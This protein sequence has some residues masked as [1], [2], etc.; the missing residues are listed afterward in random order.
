MIVVVSFVVAQLAGKLAVDVARAFTHVDAHALAGS[1]VLPARVIV[2]SMLASELVLLLAA[3][4]TPLVLAVPVRQTL[5]LYAARPRV[6]IAA[7]VGT[8][9]LGPLGDFLMA[10]LSRFLPGLTLGVVPALHE[11]ARS[12]PLWLLWPAFALMPGAGEELIF[13]GVLQ[14][15]AG[16]SAFAIW[17]SGCAFAAFHVDP[18]H[19]VGVLPLG[20]FLAWT[21]QRSGTLVTLVA[22]VVSNSVALLAIQA[23]TLDVGYGTGREM[24]WP[25]VVVSLGVVAFAALV[26]VQATAQEPRSE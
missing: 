9:M 22:H 15:A 23:D 16:R 11:I 20:L 18:V 13:R 19:V 14:R 7:A 4:L 6:F 10:S 8:V 1:S 3:F 17:L 12:L 5:G 21:A 2:P 24:P 25:W 26:I